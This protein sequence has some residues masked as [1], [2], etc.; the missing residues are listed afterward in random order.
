MIDVL[1]ING[2]IEN[3]GVC[4]YGKRLGHIL[5]NSTLYKI[6]YSEPKNLDECF[7]LIETYKPKIIV[8]NY[9]RQLIPFIDN[10]FFVY[11]K[12]KN[13]K[14]GLIIHNDA[15]WGIFDFYLHQDPYFNEYKNNKSL[16][17]PLIEFNESKIIDKTPLK[18]GTFGFFGLHKKLNNICKIVNDQIDE[19]V[20]LNLHITRCFLSNE[21]ELTD[22]KQTCLD[23]ITKP[24]I[25][26]NITHN[27][28]SD[29]DLLKHLNNNHLNIFFYDDYNFYNGISSSIDYAISCKRPFAVCKSNMFSHLRSIESKILVENNSLIDIMN[30]DISIYESL[31][32][33][34]SNNNLIEK[35]EVDIKEY[36]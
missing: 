33:K 25:K 26:L 6:L 23:N 21:S 19:E 16:L 29:I 4:Q 17:R 36:R 14:Q 1:I 8:Y 27:F 9:L 18:I 13:I 10:S 7:Q 32:N 2:S 15:S 31:N 35:F 11:I 20:E 24:N 34:W 30:N 28:L 12:E 22:I 3:C 5:K